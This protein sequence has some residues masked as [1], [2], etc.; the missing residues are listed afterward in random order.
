MSLVGK[1]GARRD[2]CHNYTVARQHQYS[3]LRAAKCLQSS[4]AK[5][6]N[7][8]EN[9][10]LQFSESVSESNDHKPMRTKIKAIIT[11]AILSRALT[12]NSKKTITIAD[13]TK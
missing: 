11:F 5:F 10:D 4:F 6:T 7:F 1:A 12:Q 8:F 9:F 3:R 13:Y 2:Y